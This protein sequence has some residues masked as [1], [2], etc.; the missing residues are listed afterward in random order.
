VSSVS[1]LEPDRELFELADPVDLSRP[2]SRLMGELLT[3]VSEPV[4][5]GYAVTLLD[6]AEP[7]RHPAALRYLGGAHADNLL[8]HRGPG[9]ELALWPAVWGARALQ[10]AW[11]PA[12]S[13]ETARVVVEHLGDERWRVAEMCSKVA[14]RREIGEAAD[15]LVA[16]TGHRLPRVRMQAVRALGKVGESEHLP[17]LRAALR[18]A[19]PDVRR[20][21]AR[22][23]E[24]CATR[25]DID[26][27]DLMEGRY[28]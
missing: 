19:D 8:R 28:R 17:V 18:D 7:F 5:A 26:L 9:H 1:G 2:S 14:G 24:L 12:R 13:G 10:Y 23:L 4:V 22:A 21:A 20:A 15:A 16:L 11:S 25:L 3:H 6:G 27:D